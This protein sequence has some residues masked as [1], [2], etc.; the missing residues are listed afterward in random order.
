MGA[1]HSRPTFCTT[2]LSSHQPWRPCITSGKAIFDTTAVPYNYAHT[3]T[4]LL[5][6]PRYGLSAFAYPASF[7]FA[8]ISPAGFR[9]RGREK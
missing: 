7:R 9:P 3:S 1:L 2:S 6:Q 5:L 4:R 8:S